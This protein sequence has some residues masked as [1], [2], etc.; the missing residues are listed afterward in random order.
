VRLAYCQKARGD[1]LERSLSVR[2]QMSKTG[3][4]IS[5]ATYTERMNANDP[6]SRVLRAVFTLI[7]DNEIIELFTVSEEAGLNLY[8]TLRELVELGEMGLLCPRRLRLTTQGLALA[9]AL[10]GDDG[11]RPAVPECRGDRANGVRASSGDRRAD[12]NRRR[13]GSCR[14]AA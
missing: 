2:P 1:R 11:V 4:I 10:Q 3:Q 7:Q 9:V 12:D 8:R 6:K 14:S 5:T 13:Q